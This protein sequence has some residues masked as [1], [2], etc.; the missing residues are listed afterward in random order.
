MDVNALNEI[1]K[2]AKLPS[3]KAFKVVEV[4]DVVF[5]LKEDNFLNEKVFA[6]RVELMQDA[7]GLFFAFLVPT[8]VNGGMSPVLE[9]I[10]RKLERGALLLGISASSPEEALGRAL[11]QLKL[12]LTELSLLEN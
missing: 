10:R 1:V 5:K 11:E 12:H 7:E 3:A 4:V 8:P 2:K 6:G 9:L